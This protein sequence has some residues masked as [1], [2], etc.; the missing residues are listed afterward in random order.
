MRGRYVRLNRTSGN[1]PLNIGGLWAYQSSGLIPVAKVALQPLF[2]PDNPA[3]NLTDGNP[4]TWTATSHS[5]EGYIE[6]D[7][8]AEHDLVELKVENRRDC[9]AMCWNRMQGT[10]LV[11]QDGARKS[12]ATYPVSAVAKDYTLRF[13]NGSIV[14]KNLVPY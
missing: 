13:E 1:E 8:G 9:G 6:I 10:T 2:S 12:V 4:D 5:T 14:E 11:V 7:L 3:T